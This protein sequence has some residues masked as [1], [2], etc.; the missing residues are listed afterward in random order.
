[1]TLRLIGGQ[2]RS[3][4]LKTPKGS[5]TRPT[6]S[7]LR[8]AVFDICQAHIDDARVLDLFAGSGAMGLEAISRGAA[9][10][11]FVEL[12]KQAVR[13]I[14]ENIRELQVEEQC[15]VLQ[16]DA[17]SCLKRLQKEGKP[18]DLIYVDP[19]YRHTLYNPI[20]QFLDQSGLLKPDGVLFVEEAHPSKLEVVLTKLM[21]KESRKFGDSL[22]HQFYTIQ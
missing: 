3:R 8:K 5:Q 16:G 14:Q 6:S 12:D 9:H 21:L 20:L 7:L 10:A 19:P 17:L 18:Y 22:L 11:T 2:F 13:C 15:R 1:M 4:L